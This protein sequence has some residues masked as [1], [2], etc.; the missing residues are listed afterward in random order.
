MPKIAM[1]GAGSA[2]FGLRTLLEL[3]STPSLYGSTLMLIDID[4]ERLTL[5]KKVSERFNE[6]FNAK[7]KIETS[8]TTKKGLDDMDFAIISIEKDR[9]YRWKLDFEIPFKYGVK[10]VLGENGGPGGLSHTLRVIPLVLEVAQ[11]IQDQ[12]KNALVFNYTNP[13]ARVTY[14][15][16]RYTKLKVIGL[17][18]GIYERID[19]FSNFL[20]INREDID[21]FAAGLNHF[22]WILEFKHRNGKNL[23]PLLDEKL[24]EDKNFEPLCREL[25]R[26]FGLYPSPSDEHVGEYI[27]FAWNKVS[28]EVRGMNWINYV[29][30]RGKE[31][32]ENAQL[33][34]LG[35]KSPKLLTLPFIR[36]RAVEIIGAIIENRKY[37]VPAVN[38]P[39]KG[40][41]TNLPRD[42]IVEI[43]AIVDGSGAHGLAIGKLPEAI[44]AMLRTQASIQKLSVEA[45]K[46]GNKEKALQ[47]LLIDPVIND[48]NIAEKIL[49][50]LI[51]IHKD[52]L[53][54]FH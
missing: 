46:E 25:Y 44:S 31:A 37:F 51:K 29:E 16:N 3:V 47:A 14:A 27:S 33:I 36:G 30:R 52:F 53:P 39:N 32:Q 54:Q 50:E 9:M 18:T 24:K 35:K 8:L 20:K 4:K 12:N 5:M 15:L 10:Q 48:E 40:N 26:I 13:E 6:E 49:E 45:A 42:I 41:I 43:P 19:S 34:A 2:T 7:L 1:I 21:I 22:T 11:D 23:Y 38:L 28:E 17:C